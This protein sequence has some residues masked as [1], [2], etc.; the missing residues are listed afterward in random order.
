LNMFKTF[1]PEVLSMGMVYYFRTPA[2]K[3]FL[4]KNKVLEFFNE[5]EFKEWQSEND[6]KVKY[7]SKYYKGLA[8]SNTKEFKEYLTNL[9][10]Y[11]IPVTVEDDSD[12]ERLDMVF[13]RGRADERKEWLDLK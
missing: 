5:H 12:F 6:G 9:D 7:T 8:T 11:L 4:P 2:V 13:G 3:V 1:W 10:H